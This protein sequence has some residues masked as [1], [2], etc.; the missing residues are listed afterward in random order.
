MGFWDK[1]K[2][3]AD[4]AAGKLAERQEEIRSLQEKYNYRD[5][6]SLIHEMKARVKTEGVFSKDA[7][8]IKLELR[9]RGYTDQ[10]ISTIIQIDA[11]I[12]RMK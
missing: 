6:D 1:L 8:A 11:D 9:D 5:A 2:S 7:A 12:E 10:D 3:V 4:S